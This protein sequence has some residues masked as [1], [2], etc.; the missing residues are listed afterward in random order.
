MSLK[1]KI[2]RSI[3]ERWLH[4]PPNGNHL[5]V[6]KFMAFKT[7]LSENYK[8]P[9]E[10]QYPPEKLFYLAKRN[11]VKIGLWID[12]TNTNRYYDKR[13]VEQEGCQYIKLKCIGHGGPPSVEKT[14]LFISLV[15]EYIIKHPFDCIAV[16]CTH[17]FNRTGFLIISFLIV[18]LGFDTA[19]ALEVFAQSRPPGIY[20]QDYI[21]EL[22]RRYGNIKDVPVAPALPEWCEVENHRRKRKSKKS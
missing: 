3:P 7:P 14:K 13:V 16:H 19:A 11:G 4:C 10:F 17:G 21:N 12:L 8:V 18:Q 15:H 22:F 2:S 5:I 1:G 6:A 20:K 9:P